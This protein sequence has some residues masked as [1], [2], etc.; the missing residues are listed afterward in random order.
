MRGSSLQVQRRRSR[1][2]WHQAQ[3]MS[4][5]QHNDTRVVGVLALQGAFREHVQALARLGYAAVEVRTS[6][7]L[8]QVDGLIIPGGESTA[9]AKVAEADGFIEEFKRWREEF[10]AKPVW[11]VCAGAILLSN[12]V[13]GQK[14]GGQALFGGVDITILRNAFGSQIDSFV[15]D[16][17]IP[18]VCHG[19][20]EDT[21]SC[22]FIRAPVI[23]AVGDHVDVLATVKDGRIVAAQQ[24]RYLVTSFHPELTTDTRFHQYFVDMIPR[25]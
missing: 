14:R 21:M 11:G 15:E 23:T 18:A 16:V 22:V 3:A 13:E 20:A 4:T 7:Q 19:G 25:G 1:A 12:S 5:H 9:I 8:W 24:G 17:H 2:V 6:A 10:P